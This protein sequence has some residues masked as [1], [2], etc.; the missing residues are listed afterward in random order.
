MGLSQ[1]RRVDFREIYAPVIKYGT[2]RFFLALV[3]Q[4]RMKMLKVNFESAF[5]NGDLQEEMLL[6]Q[7]DSFVLEAQEQ[8]TMHLNKALYGL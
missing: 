1:K 5:L 8:K 6:A 2:L 7:P 3:G 4:H